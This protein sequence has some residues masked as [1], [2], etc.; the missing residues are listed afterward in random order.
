LTL[1]PL[2]DGSASKSHVSP[3]QLTVPDAPETVSSIDGLEQ[4]AEEDSSAGAA[5]NPS[6]LLELL[7]PLLLELLIPL[8]LELLIPLLLE[9][10]VSPRLLLDDEKARLLLDDEKARLLLEL[11]RNSAH[12]L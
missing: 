11:L 2:S 8:L 6:L 7:I 10:L 4:S 3:H 12:S 1:L 9:L 5:L